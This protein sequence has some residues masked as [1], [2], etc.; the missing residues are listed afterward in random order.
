MPHVTLSAIP[1]PS[2]VGYDPGDAPDYC[3]TEDEVAAMSTEEI[4]SLVYDLREELA[5]T[6]HELAQSRA[7]RAAVAQPIADLEDLKTHVTDIVNEMRDMSPR[8]LY[9]S[10]DRLYDAI[11]DHCDRVTRAARVGGGEE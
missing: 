6:A 3:P 7:A 11:H 8:S 9:K 4:A 10:I 2:S 1:C 5:D